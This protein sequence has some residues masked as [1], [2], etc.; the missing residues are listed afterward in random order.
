MKTNNSISTPSRKG[1]INRT[2]IGIGL[3]SLFSDWSHEIAT[4]VLPAFLAT[5]GVSALWLGLIEGISD[6]LSSFAKMGSGYYTDKLQRRKPIA[7]IGYLITALGTASFAFA[8]TAWH[9]LL[10]RSMAWL[11]RGVRTPIRKALLA[12]SVTRETYGRAFGF[13]RMMDTCGAIVGPASAFFL[14]QI[15]NHNYSM[16]FTLTLIPGLLA[17][18][19]IAFAVKEKLRMPV[20][21]ISFGERLRLLPPA[22][23]KFL[24]A[25]GLF[26]AGDF[27][28]TLLILLATQ[29]LIPVMGMTKAAST[30]AALYVWHN[31]IYA[32]FSFIAGGLADRFKKNYVLAAGYF[33]A[34][35]M[36]IA[37]II[38]P[39]TIWSLA[40]IFTLGGIYIAVE[41]TVEDSFCAELVDESHHG[42]AFGILATVNGI[43]DFL[44]SIVVGFLW[45]WAGTSVAFGYSAFLFIAGAWLISRTQITSPNDVRKKNQ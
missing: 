21:H 2:V 40:I 26:G 17:A 30:A 7:I 18:A 14:L 20:P 39:S 1:W 38:L 32:T 44:S 16:L 13:E 6:G 4:T 33:V 19:L 23:H 28:H 36:V 29:K 34:V 31:I 5:M 25:V 8:T 35:I 24:I 3:A 22:F 15:L 42:M 37:I 11:G 43:G 9:V 45:S 12:G 41:E 27:A 10:A